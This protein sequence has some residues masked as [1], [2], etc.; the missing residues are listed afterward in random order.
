VKERHGAALDHEAPER[1]DIEAVDSRF[2]RD[3]PVS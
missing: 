3:R 1:I 2:E